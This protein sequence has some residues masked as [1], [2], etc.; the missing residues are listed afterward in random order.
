MSKSIVESI[1]SVIE[2]DGD[3]A[4]CTC[5]GERF[6]SA[7][8][9]KK[10]CIVALDKVPS[11]FCFHSSCMAVIQEYN[12]KLRRALWN[13]EHQEKR[14]YTD[15]EKREI[16]VRIKQK[17]ED[18]S[19]KEWGVKNK[20]RLF[21]KF[22]WSMADAFNESPITSDDP[23]EDGRLFLS[24][25]F[26]LNDVI[27]IGQPDQSGQRFESCFQ[28]VS[29]WIQVPI[30]GN[31]TC[32][33]VFKYGSNSRSNES[34]ERQPYLV[35][36]SD[37][38]TMD[39]SCSLYKWMNTFLRLRSIV[40]SGNKSAHGWFEFP[41]EKLFQRLKILL[42]AMGCDW[43]LFRKS[44]PVRMPGVLRGDKYQ[45]LCYLTK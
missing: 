22:Q 4:F 31:F 3:K 2:W 18:E 21:N 34:V 8:D 39:E 37:T 1:V 24:T 12:L 27:W 14:E 40:H 29:H 44:Q 28:P 6:H 5:P 32:P 19:L 42:P 16:A 41:S 10:D 13:N 43:H 33:C 23:S 9:G 45:H 25:L 7:K 17:K 20:E 30:N 38:M 36:E 26:E 11:I 15:Q 35:V